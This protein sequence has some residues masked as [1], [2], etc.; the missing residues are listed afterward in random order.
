MHWKYLPPSGVTMGDYHRLV[1]VKIWKDNTYK[2]KDE[3]YISRFAEGRVTGIGSEP[4]PIVVVRRTIDVSYQII[5][6]SLLYF[7]F[8]SVVQLVQWLQN[9]LKCLKSLKSLKLIF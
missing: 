4:L 3:T 6:S 7:F 1:K 9:F 8:F 2:T 5:E